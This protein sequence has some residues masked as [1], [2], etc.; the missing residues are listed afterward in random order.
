MDPE[1]LAKLRD[2]LAG[3]ASRMITWFTGAL[4]GVIDGGMA[5]V[6]LLSL[7]VITPVVA[8]Y[9]LRDWDLIVARID[10]WLPRQH[11]AEIRKQARAVDETLGGFVRGQGTVCLVLGVFYAIGLEP[12]RS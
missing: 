4:R 2:A 10:S 9:L 8:F 12:G 6:N 1:L 5:L 11:Q 3:S 7:V